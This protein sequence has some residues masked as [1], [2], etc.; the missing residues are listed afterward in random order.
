MTRRLLTTFSILAVL[1]TAPLAVLAQM[2]GG[3]QV[4]GV[5]SLPTGML[6]KDTLLEQ[7]KGMVSDLTS[8]KSSGKLDATQTKQVDGML[9]KAQSLTTE[10]EKPQVPPSKLSQL[11]SSLSD[12]QKQMATLKSLVK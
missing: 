6:S 9:P 3:V 11:A 2:P 12:L 10:L 5:G 7:A 1:L 8:M 4:P